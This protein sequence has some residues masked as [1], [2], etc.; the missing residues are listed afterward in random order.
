MIANKEKLAEEICKKATY[1]MRLITGYELVSERFVDCQGSLHMFCAFR[2]DGF[3]KLVEI[4]KEAF[5]NIFSEYLRGFSPPKMV[6]PSTE[7]K[8][9]DSLLLSLHVQSGALQLVCNEIVLGSKVLETVSGRSIRFGWGVGFFIG[10]KS[11]SF[12]EGYPLDKWSEI[13]LHPSSPYKVISERKCQLIQLFSDK[14]QRAFVAE[15]LKDFISPLSYDLT[16]VEL[17][18]DLTSVESYRL[19][20][21]AKQG[22][23]KLDSYIFDL[24]F[25]DKGVALSFKDDVNDV[26]KDDVKVN[27]HAYMSLFAHEM[28]P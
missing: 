9:Q 14:K 16:S 18:Y 13:V 25:I 3:E 27:L 5:E 4:F 10:S 1:S 15:R 2:K 24:Y 28:L 8:P 22:S 11:G 26:N 7:I 12:Y 23:R 17:S 20:L 19:S 21:Y 6:P